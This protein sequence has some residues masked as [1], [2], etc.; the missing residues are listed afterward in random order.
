M[1]YAEQKLGF[2]TVIQKEL[3]SEPFTENQEYFFSP[4]SIKFEES[5]KELT[6]SEPLKVMI[7]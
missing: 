1:Q 7:A 3:K 2:S 5:G 4:S 6:F